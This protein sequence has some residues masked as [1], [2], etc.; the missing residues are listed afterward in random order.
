MGFSRFF[1]SFDLLF[2]AGSCTAMPCS[3]QSFNSHPKA[4]TEAAALAAAALAQM[5][6]V[7]TAPMQQQ[8]AA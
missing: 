1:L 5:C 8:H 2:V 6:S 7:L 3:S 4:A